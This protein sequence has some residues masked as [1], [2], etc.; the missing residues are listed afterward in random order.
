MIRLYLEGTYIDL[1]DLKFEIKWKHPVMT[2]LIGESTDYS[3]DIEIDLSKNNRLVTDYKIL[4]DST[5]TNKWLYGHLF[6]N[7]E[8]MAVRVYVKSFTKTKIVIFLQKYKTGLTEFLQDTKILSELFMPEIEAG[9]K[10]D[11]ILNMQDGSVPS[12]ILP[13]AA[14]LPNYFAVGANEWAGNRPMVYST[15]LI[16][17][18]ADK[19]GFAVSN[20]PTNYRVFAN[21]WKTGKSV[22]VESN[23][24]KNYTANVVQFNNSTTSGN[25]RLSG[26]LIYSNVKFKLSLRI[27]NF[28]FQF[29]DSNSHDVSFYITG[30][31]IETLIHTESGIYPDDSTSVE[32][33]YSGLNAGEYN[34]TAKAEGQ[35]LVSSGNCVLQVESIGITEGSDEYPDFGLVGHYPCYK[36]LPDITAKQLFETVACASGRMIEYSEN[37]VK[38]IDFEDVFGIDN[39]FDASEFLIEFEEKTF[40]VLENKKNTVVYASGREIAL[41]YVNDETLSNDENVVADLNCIRVQDDTDEERNTEDLILQEIADG[42]FDIIEKLPLLYAPL[43]SPKVFKCKF[44]YF[45]ENRRPLLVRQLNGIFVV[46]ESIITNENTIVLELLKVK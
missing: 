37:T 39:T 32:F 7:G 28:G 6:V 26:N 16:Q 22:I 40:K 15:N 3:T 43:I 19:Y 13:V 45:P 27:L 10:R 1:T 21:K 5:K 8:Q 31:G 44:M 25:F 9:T 33:T 17:V 23:G 41:F 4:Q 2:S 14:S 30:S 29:G 12:F 36:N 18:L 38:F 24:T 46:L 42:H 34:I 20:A 35:V 11:V